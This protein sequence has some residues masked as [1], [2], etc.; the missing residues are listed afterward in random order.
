MAGS[1]TDVTPEFVN[2]LTYNKYA[3]RTADTVQFEAIR[4]MQSSYV[5]PAMPAVKYQRGLALLIAH[6]YA[7]DD[8]QTPDAGDLDTSVG[9]ITSER[10]GDV[11]RTR[12]NQPY[13][14]TVDGWKQYLMLTTYGTEFLYLMKTFKMSPRV[15]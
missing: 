8:T 11:S 15:S 7:L 4:L 1:I 5:N 6:Y 10:V 14:G 3:S 2:L 9:A 12:G 13:L